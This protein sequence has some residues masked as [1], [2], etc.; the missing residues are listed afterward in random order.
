MEPKRRQ[1]VQELMVRF[2]DGDRSAF[3]LLFA[4]LWPVLLA[5]TSR[6]LSSS[7][8]AEDAAQAS[9]LKI[10]ARVVDFERERDAV[11]W[12]YGI[13]AFEVLTLRKRQ[14]RRRESGSVKLH[15]VE[16]TELSPERH[17]EERSVQQ[18]ILQL[19]SELS[20]RDQ[21]ALELE[22]SDSGNRLDE[23]ERKQR[24]RALQRLRDAWRKL[25]G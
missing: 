13:A 15:D 21:L 18:V 14:Q 17:V 22:F 24:F 8:E 7:A 2:A 25:N 4:K 1:E 23:T 12:A 3:D 19:A 10:F 11:S 5:Y 6:A 20:E 16:S 9:L